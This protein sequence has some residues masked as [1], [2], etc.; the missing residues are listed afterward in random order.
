MEVF[1]LYVLFAVTTSL[2][3][4]YELV[5]P[6]ISLRKTENLPTLQLYILYPVFV[7]LNTIIAPLVFLSC[8]VP[9]FGERFRVALYNGLYPKE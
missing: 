7:V 1:L 2:T 9:S 5:I 3:S 4:I 6:V 8:I